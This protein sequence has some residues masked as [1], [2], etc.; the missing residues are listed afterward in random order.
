M[1]CKDRKHREAPK[2]TLGATLTSAQVYG[3]REPIDN[4]STGFSRQAVCKRTFYDVGHL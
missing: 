4:M 3:W 1:W 2:A